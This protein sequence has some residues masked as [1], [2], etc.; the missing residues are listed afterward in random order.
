MPEMAFV[1][2]W[3]ITYGGSEGV[4]S[5]L[6]E[7]WPQVPIY[8]MICD[9][10][11]P[12]KDIIENHHVIPSFIQKLPFAKEHHQ[13][14]L[15]VMLFAVEQFDFSN[16][17][18]IVSSSHA[19]AKGILSGADQLH[20]SYVHSPIRYAWDLQHQ[21]LK[22]SGMA[23][24]LKGGVVRLLLHYMRMWDLRT[25]NSVDIFIAN[26]NFIAR[27]IRKLYNRRSRVIYPPVD[28][29]SFSFHEK[30]EDFYLTVSRVVPYK[31]IDLIINV[32][33][34]MPSKKLFVIGGG[35]EL[36]R[37]RENAGPNIEFLGYQSKNVIIDYMQHA[38][39]FLFAAVEDFGIVSVEAQ[40]CGTPVVAYGKGGSLE[41]V[42]DGET[43][44]F[45]SQQTIES[46]QSTLCRFEDMETFFSRQKIRKNAERFSKQR[47]QEEIKTLIEKEWD[48]FHRKRF[49]I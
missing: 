9:R 16:Y 12:C 30:K 48:K 38:K 18:I 26:S 49:V 21:Y 29:N 43:G 32:F 42:I 45:F 11:G 31:R 36:D 28:L 46:L 27:R 14:Y 13:M 41:T 23:K 34:K 47:F 5:A 7:L 33:N 39:A 19:V 44:L 22:E 3:L 17:D 8:T 10:N 35:P 15:P 24:G 4:V 6:S 2:D 1:H 37:L 40:A 25:I 20:I